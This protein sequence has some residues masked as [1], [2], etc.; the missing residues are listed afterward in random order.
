MFEFSISYLEESNILYKTKAKAITVRS[1]R[2]IC[3]SGG[4]QRRPAT[5][6]G[7]PLK[8]VKQYSR[9]ELRLLCTMII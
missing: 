9:Y 5:R 4:N 8:M 3:A 6:K 1:R 2:V 7:N